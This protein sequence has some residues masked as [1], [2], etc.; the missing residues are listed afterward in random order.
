VVA[1][2]DG[3]LAIVSRQQLTAGVARATLDL[4]RASD[5]DDRVDMHRSRHGLS[6]LE[7]GTAIFAC[8]NRG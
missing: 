5:V 8:C 6:R 4:V 1:E 2:H 3:V 7:V